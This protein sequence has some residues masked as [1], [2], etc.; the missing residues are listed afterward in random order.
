MVC[1][2]KFQISWE[3]TEIVARSNF[4]CQRYG[5]FVV[6]LQVC[7]HRCPPLQ[8]GSEGVYFFLPCDS[9]DHLDDVVPATT[10]M[11]SNLG[12]VNVEALREFSVEAI[13]GPTRFNGVDLVF[14]HM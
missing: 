6:T 13:S 7:F 9:L 4:S 1:A 10:H 8:V 2:T 11:I 12:K 5:D 14:N 3:L